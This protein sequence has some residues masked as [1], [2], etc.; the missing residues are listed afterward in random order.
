MPKSK[1]VFVCKECSY[2]NPKWLGKCPNCGVWNSF[3][4]Q[5][6][7]DPDNP[8]LT[9]S[10]NQNQNLLVS[11]L[12]D[13]LEQSKN[14][15][16]KRFYPFASN[17]LNQFWG[18]G[19]VVGSLTLL[20][21]EPGLGKSTL[22]LQLLRSLFFG[23]RANPPKLLY[24]TAEES[25]ME[26][27]RRSQRLE[28]PKQI[29]V[30]QSNQFEQIEKVIQTYKPQ[31]VVIDSIQT[32]FSNQ[33]DSN[34][35]SISQVSS[36]TSGFLAICKSLSISIIIIGHVTKEGQI[37]GPKTLEHLVDSVI[38]IEPTKS[39]NYRILSFAKHRFGNTEEM[40][41]LKMEPSGLEIVTDPSLALLENLETGIGVV[42]GV[43]MDKNLP[44]IVEIQT[45]VNSPSKSDGVFGRREA[46]GFSTSKLNTILAVIEKYLELNLK[47][48]DVY[49]QISG[50]PKNINDDS[51][52]LPVMLSILSSV[53]D[54]PIEE[55][56]KINDKQKLKKKIFAG[57]LTL[58]GKIR[59]PTNQKQRQQVAKNLGFEF[60]QNIKFG[61]LQPL[62]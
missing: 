60:N 31:V 30:M 36:L 62:F 2:E 25:I 26:L 37:A 3:E 1:T 13:V 61:D 55:V 54:Q 11:S 20:A 35:G 56:L 43:A 32:I 14:N 50:L 8:N 22:A 24:V 9:K 6:K 47:N 27:A 38:L 51:L 10:I 46:L 52:D 58:S 53:Y 57:R 4:E 16:E 40:L 59:K 12:A 39:K 45:L 23:E 7:S 28:I 34:P 29:W 33:L 49:V 17:A 48:C 18:G 42:Y 5:L 19:L 41:L 21:G 44:L 15:S